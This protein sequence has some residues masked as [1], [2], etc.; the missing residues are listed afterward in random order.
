MMNNDLLH[1]LL[2]WPWDKHFNQGK[3]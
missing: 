1:N 2:W 3:I